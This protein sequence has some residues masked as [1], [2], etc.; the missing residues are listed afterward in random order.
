MPIFLRHDDFFNKLG[1]ELGEI[2]YISPQ[3]REQGDLS[4]VWLKIDLMDLVGVPPVMVVVTNRG[5][6]SSRY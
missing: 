4:E 5:V 6:I 1:A 3:S 2:V